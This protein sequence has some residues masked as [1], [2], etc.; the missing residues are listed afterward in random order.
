MTHTWKNRP[1]YGGDRTQAEELEIALRTLREDR[2]R[3]ER[4]R[5]GT[6]PPVTPKE[7]Q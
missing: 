1:K 6:A 3:Q 4:E 5:K 7:K 2:E